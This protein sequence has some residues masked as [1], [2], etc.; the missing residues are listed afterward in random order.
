M[1]LPV[2]R[3]QSSKW[4]VTKEEY[5]LQ[6]FPD[7]LS[8]RKYFYINKFLKHIKHF[9]YMYINLNTFIPSM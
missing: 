7:F 5:E 4:F 1:N 2:I 6:V 9:E 3:D 8:G